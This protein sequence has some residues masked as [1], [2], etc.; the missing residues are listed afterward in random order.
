M[1]AVVRMPQTVKAPIAQGQ[2]I[3]T[4]VLT[5]A[6]GTPM[7]FPLVAAQPVERLGLFGRISA[8]LSY[9]VSGSPKAS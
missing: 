2:P 6:G 7:E 1:K 9:L 5:T 4:L 3:G 8:A